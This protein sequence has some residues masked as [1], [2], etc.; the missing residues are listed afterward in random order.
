MFII[1]ILYWEVDGTV[2]ELQ[3]KSLPNMITVMSGFSTSAI[4]KLLDIL[5]ETISSCV[6]GAKRS[7]IF[8]F[9]F[10]FFFFFFL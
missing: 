2:V 10:V 7:F 8:L 6:C 4:V 5:G 9:C 1:Q 3:A